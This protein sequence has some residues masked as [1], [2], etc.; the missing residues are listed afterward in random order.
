MK[1][2]QTIDAHS[3]R[4][5]LASDDRPIL[6]NAL[7]RE[8]FDTER[9]PGSISIPAAQALRLADELLAHDQP[10]VTYCASRSCTASRRRR[11]DHM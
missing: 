3:L 8:A 5:R 2:Y 1:K 10:I 7:A 9:I 4:D 11:S 6:V